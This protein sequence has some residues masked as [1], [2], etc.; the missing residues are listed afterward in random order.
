MAKSNAERQKDLRARRREAGIALV[1]VVLEPSDFQS[2]LRESRI[3]EVT[4]R[5]FLIRAGRR[6]V[7]ERQR[8]RGEA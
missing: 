7:T 8:R 6:R 5:E 4:L 1:D 2:F 3:E